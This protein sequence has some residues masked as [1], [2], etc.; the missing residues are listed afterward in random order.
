MAGDEVGPLG[1]GVRGWKDLAGSERVRRTRIISS[2]S[3]PDVIAVHAR[4][5]PVEKR[6]SWQ[7]MRS[8][9]QPSLI[10]VA[11]GWPMACAMGG[12]VVGPSALGVQG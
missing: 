9:L 11:C 8:G 12:Y 1:L 3:G 6:G 4:S 2:A 5:F 10:R 7:G